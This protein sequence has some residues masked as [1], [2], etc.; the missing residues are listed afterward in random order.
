MGIVKSIAQ[1][2]ARRKDPAERRAEIVAAASRIAVGEGLERVTA[3]RVA[4]ELGVVPGLVN[5]YFSAVD[6]LVAAAFGF[7]SRLE[8]SE[9]YA[10]AGSAGSPLERLRRVLADL[11]NPQRDAVSLLWLDAWQASRRRP[12]LLSEVIVQM[13]EDAAELSRLVA[14]GVAAGE[15]ASDDPYVSAV[16][17]MALVD[18]YGV[19]AAARSR[20]DSSIVA[21]FAR[22][23][24]ESELGLPPSV[25]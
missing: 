13:D 17:I 4:E 2:K 5:H 1:P 6:D 19:Q 16:R 21:T 12:A 7:A 18:G 9:I 23:A 14:A 15:F 11:L 3:K 8:R 24:T 20:S 22:R 25:L 10:D